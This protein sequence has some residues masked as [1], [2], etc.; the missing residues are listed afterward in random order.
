MT[1]A[2]TVIQLTETAGNKLRRLTIEGRAT[3][4]ELVEASL[5][6]MQELVVLLDVIQR[7]QLFIKPGIREVADRYA[8]QIMSMATTIGSLHARRM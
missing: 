4:D 2:L 1:A 6:K 3:A 8:E 7:D 5:F